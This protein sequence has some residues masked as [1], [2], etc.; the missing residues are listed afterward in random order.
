MARP[1]GRVW[2]ALV[3]IYVLWGS[4]FMAVTIAVRDLPPLLS[5]AIRH[6]A[7]GAI[8]LAWALPRGDRR[9]DRIG[10]SEV[11]AALVFGGALFLV[12]H[13]GLAWAQQTVPSGV[14]AL[15]VGSIPLWMALLDRVLF[16]KRLHASA[17][18][19]LVGGFLG[20]AFLVDPIGAGAVDRVGALV[21]VGSAFAW[22]A[23]SLYSRGATLPQ[24]PLVSAGLAALCGG[25]LL[26][27]ASA[28]SGEL[29]EARFSAESLGAVAYLVVAGTL[30]GF[31]AYVWLLRAAPTS[32]VST[33]AYVNPI[34]AVA[35]G[36]ALLGEEIT[37]QMLVAGSAILVSVA[38]I[39]RSS[40][41]ALEPG[42][43]LRRPRAP[44]APA[45]AADGRGASGG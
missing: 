32:L 5:M 23:G 41:A 43:G 18:V 25:V 20:L 30:V 26:S 44:A 38:L 34:V 28:A 33:Y 8:L 22:A 10:W 36:W 7:A 29:D 13:G 15:L 21:A 9:A 14:A 6:L 1:G 37:A 17:N 42:R 24:R 11:R 12:G 27:L 39:V 16:G 40:G 3:T 45:P 4:T 31:S 2:L 19:G 35:L